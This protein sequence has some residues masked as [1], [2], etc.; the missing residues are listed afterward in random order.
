MYGPQQGGFWSGQKA[1]N[2]GT[3]YGF[4]TAGRWY[5]VVREFADFDGDRHPIGETWQFCGYSFVPYEDGLSLFVS[6]DGRQ[7]WQL[8]M[9]SRAEAQGPILDHLAEYIEPV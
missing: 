5:Q 7:E 1:L 6:V 9:Q 2:S 4:L 3:A 8:R